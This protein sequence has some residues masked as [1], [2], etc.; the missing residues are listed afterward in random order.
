M[1]VPAAAPAK[2]RASNTRQ[3][4]LDAGAK[5]FADH[6]YAG[7]SLNDLIRA[8]GLTKGAFYFHFAS[9]EALALE[10]YAFKQ[11]QWGVAIQ[12]AMAH[13]ERALDQVIEAMREGVRLHRTDPNGRCVARLCW[14]LGED[15]KLRPLMVPFAENWFQVLETLFLRAQEEGDVRKAVD[16]RALAETSFAAFIGMTDVAHLMSQGADLEERT[17]AFLELLLSAIS[18][19][20]GAD[21]AAT[22]AT[23]RGREKR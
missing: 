14:E 3:L 11:E 15:E 12:D 23:E 10:V 5:S 13:K 19:G 22:P 6:G 17:E 1:I 8:T 16:A 7:T 18:E 20:S 9:K 21:D 4:I 2:D